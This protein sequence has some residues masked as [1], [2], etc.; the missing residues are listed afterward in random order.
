MHLIFFLIVIITILSVSFGKIVD[1]FKPILIEKKEK[2]TDSITILLNENKI[3]FTSWEGFITINKS[4]K[5][6]LGPKERNLTYFYNEED[7][8][9]IEEGFLGKL[10]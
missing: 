9:K 6:I 10:F 7:S 1:E 8:K 4:N 5:R 3:I 2:I